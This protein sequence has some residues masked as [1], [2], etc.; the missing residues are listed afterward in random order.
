MEANPALKP[1]FN[2]GPFPLGGDHTT[3]WA[4]GASFHDLNTDR[5]VGPP[6]RLIADLSDLR[7]S[8]GLLSPGQSGNPSSPHYDDQAQAW[9]TASYHRLLYERNEVE[10]ETIS[11]LHLLP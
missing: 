3:V 7:N 1:F 8:L 6:F 9:H 4:T 10:V 11:V 2:R 5:V